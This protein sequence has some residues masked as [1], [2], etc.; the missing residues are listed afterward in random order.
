MVACTKDPV[1]VTG[2]TL[3]RPTALMLVGHTLALE[4]AVEPAEAANQT[5]TWSTD[6]DRVATVNPA[7]GVTAVAIGTATITATADNG[8]FTATCVVTV[9]AEPNITMTTKASMG[10]LQYFTRNREHVS[11]S[12]NRSGYP[13]H[14]SSV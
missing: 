8:R 4:A 10:N 7:G 14:S 3:N 2:V 5:V 1:H 9:A 13:S 6:D 12:K 11:L